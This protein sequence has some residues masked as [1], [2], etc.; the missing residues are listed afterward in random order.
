MDNSDTVTLVQT[1]ARCRKWSAMGFGFR[2]VKGQEV[3]L[4]NCSECRRSIRKVKNAYAKTEKGRKAIAKRSRIWNSS[5]G[6]KSALKRYHK[7]DKYDVAVKKYEKSEKGKAKQKRRNDKIM[8]DPGKHLMKMICNRLSDVMSGRRRGDSKKLADYT[9]FSST[10]EA[11]EHFQSLFLEG[12]TL[13]NYGSFWEIDHIIA[14]KWYDE[15]D[16]EDLMRCW[17]KSNLQPLEGGENNKKRIEIPDEATLYRIGVDKWP[18]SWNGIPPDAATRKAWYKL[19]H[20]MR[21][22]RV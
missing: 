4:K 18:K 3:Q 9:S 5:D 7:T 21:M 2:N 8:T 20:D 19:H 22:G 11:K 13:E 14:R 15:N 12:M 6:H 16:E 1:C 17:H 10:E